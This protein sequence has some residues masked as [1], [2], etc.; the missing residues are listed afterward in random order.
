MDPILDPTA[1][2]RTPSSPLDDDAVVGDERVSDSIPPPAAVVGAMEAEFP[3]VPRGGDVVEDSELVA[4]DG[5]KRKQK[6][7]L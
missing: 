6:R 2:P 7:P 5:F 4:T 3:S 1:T